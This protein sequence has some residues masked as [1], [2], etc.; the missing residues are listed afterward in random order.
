MKSITGFVWMLLGCAMAGT[1]TAEVASAAPACPSEQ[2]AIAA[3]C[4]T[5]EEAANRI[6]ASL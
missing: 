4:V 3:R 2:I 5:L 6:E 1:L